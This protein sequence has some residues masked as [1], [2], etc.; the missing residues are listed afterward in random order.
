MREANV[1]DNVVSIVHHQR[2]REA[3]NTFEQQVELISL[4]ISQPSFDSFG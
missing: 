2:R 4:I 3:V 1:G